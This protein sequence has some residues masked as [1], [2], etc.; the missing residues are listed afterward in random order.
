MEHCRL[1]LAWGVLMAL[2]VLLA[3]AAPLRA[4]T[5]AEESMR[6]MYWTGCSP[7]KLIVAMDSD[8]AVRMGLTEEAI[9]TAVRSRLRAARLYTDTND[10][11][12]PLLV[13]H[14]GVVSSKRITGGAFSIDVALHKHLY[15]PLSGHSFSAQTNDIAGLL[16]GILGLHAGNA[17]F[18]LSQ[19]G[20]AMDGFIDTYLRVN[21]P[22]CPRS[23][24]DP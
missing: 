11:E 16:Y 5:N 14:V 15:D 9:A 17:A 21:E 13:M 7:L 22:A 8:D 4:V 1:R 20:R 6:F 12:V 3:V 18:I 19:I 23:P 10:R 24:I 2:S